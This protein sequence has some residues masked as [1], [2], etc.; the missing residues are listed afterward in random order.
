MAQLQAAEPPMSP[1]DYLRALTPA[2]S[3]R[4]ADCTEPVVARWNR[5]GKDFLYVTHPDGTALGYWDLA[6][7]ESHPESPEFDDLLRLAV[8][9]WVSPQEISPQRWP[10]VV[11]LF[12]DV[13]DGTRSA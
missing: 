13:R 5:Y 4:G 1:A 11:N 9:D 10:R 6:T 3:G 12:G 2:G 7:Q 8:K